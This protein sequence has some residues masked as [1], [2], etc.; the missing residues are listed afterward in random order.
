MKRKSALKS[1]SFHLRSC[2]T[3][4]RSLLSCLS[5]VKPCFDCRPV[6]KSCPA[7]LIQN[8]ESYCQRFQARAFLSILECRLCTRLSGCSS[9]CGIRAFPS[10]CERFCADALAIFLWISTFLPAKKL[11]GT[12]VFW[13]IVSGVACLRNQV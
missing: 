9:V 8:F 7:C 5:S 6:G 4:A 10:C 3:A 1:Y 2:T 12:F 13:S 11:S